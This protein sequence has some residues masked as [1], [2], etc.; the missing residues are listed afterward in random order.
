MVV[1]HKHGHYAFIAGLILA[2]IAALFQI[3]SSWV[4][5]VL[6]VLGIIVG[7]LNIRAKDM[8]AFLVAV[9]AL[10]AAGSANLIV[11]NTIFDPLGS[12][13][14]A[15]LTFIKVFVAPA[16]VVVSFKAVKLLADK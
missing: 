12:T 8:T 13:L 16:A 1:H 4:V 6:V 11:L 5:L 2:I 9:I 10:I 3:T 14:S 15:M 7:I